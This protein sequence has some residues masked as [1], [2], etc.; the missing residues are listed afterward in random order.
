[1]LFICVLLVSVI[2]SVLGVLYLDSFNFRNK[3]RGNILL[4]VLVNGITL[5]LYHKYDISNYF[6]VLTYI[7]FILILI[8]VTDIINK[9]VPLDLI[10]VSVII[11]VLMFFFNPNISVREAVIGFL[12]LGGVLIMLSRLTRGAFGMGDSLVI[13]VLGLFLGWQ[14]CLIILLYSFVIS[15]LVG[16][17]LM[18]FKYV[19]RKSTLPFVPFVLIAFLIV[20]LGN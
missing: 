19:N 9:E 18:I 4:L 17:V 16:L 13:S 14:I 6:I 10:S 11:G 15:G 1:M 7:A 12:G 3:K 20:I 8:S 2:M 5:L